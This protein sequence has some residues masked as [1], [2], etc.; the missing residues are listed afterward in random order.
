MLSN[1][2]K[3]LSTAVFF[4]FFLVLCYRNKIKWVFYKI[5]M[6]TPS[7]SKTKGEWLLERGVWYK[8][9]DKLSICLVQHSKFDEIN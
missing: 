5:S 7:V 8:R 4:F 3:I 2:N 9:E 6:K 1:R